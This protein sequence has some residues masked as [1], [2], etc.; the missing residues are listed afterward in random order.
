MPQQVF[1]KIAREGF[2]PVRVGGGRVVFRFRCD[3]TGEDLFSSP[4]DMVFPPLHIARH[5]VRTYFRCNEKRGYVFCAHNGS[6]LPV[7]MVKDKPI[8]IKTSNRKVVS[9]VQMPDL[10]IRIR[11]HVRSVKKSH[12][13]LVTHTLF[14]GAPGRLPWYS[15]YQDALNS[16][17]HPPSSG[18][19][20]GFPAKGFRR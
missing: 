9:L 1:R 20:Y 6:P 8:C 17:L 13:H 14:E 12:V 2:D 7:I 15:V 18:I 5:R 19:T 4:R 11:V 16:L 3:A 10:R